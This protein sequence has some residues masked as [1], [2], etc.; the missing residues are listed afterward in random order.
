MLACSLCF[1]DGYIVCSRPDEIPAP[2]PSVRLHGIAVLPRGIK[3]RGR[4][5]MISPLS[6]E[7]ARGVRIALPPDPRHISTYVFLE[8]EDWFEDEADFVS[9]AAEPGGRMLDVGSSF[10][11]YSLNYARAGGAAARVWA[12][13]PTPEVCIL[14]RESIR[15][16]GLANMT[17]VET[18]VGAA[19]GRARFA[20]G[21]HSELNS[22]DTA[23]GSLE[24]A[25]ATLDDLDQ[26]HGFGTVDFVKLDVEGHEAEVVTGGV[27]F[28]KR[29][30]PL[31][32][33]EI[34]A[35]SVL[36]FTAAERF[37]ALGYA[38]YRLVPR[39]GVLVPFERTQVDPFLLN[40][41]ACKPDR[42]A[43]LADRGMLCTAI[44]ASAP[45]AERE[46]VAAC[47]RGI[48]AL[49]GHAAFFENLLAQAPADDP[50]TLLLRHEVASRNGS[51]PL[52]GRCAAL[53]AAA[54]IARQS[55]AAQ[56]GLAKMLGAA[57]VL[58]GW[59]E[60]GAAAGVLQRL[61]PAVLSGSGLSLD[62]PFLPPLPEYDARGGEIA[63]WLSACIVE[64]AALWS[65]YSSYWGEP[66]NVPTSDL[67]QRFGQQSAQFER[68][69]QLRRMLEGRQTGPQANP[70]LKAKSPENLNPEF[71][72]G[73]TT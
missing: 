53:A 19:S 47:I 9:R 22:L 5:T 41:F 16:N 33:L 34:K 64:A 28:F 29:E 26:E 45:R 3:Q 27:V 43:R 31:V 69:R 4:R 39:L 71:W 10:G 36:D 40:V 73:P 63:A 54:A 57:R 35:G 62:A 59:G 24:V 32:M 14:L 38:L 44:A 18:A 51:I 70:L 1:Q 6:L 30:S 68:R 15:Q 66:T 72:C 56:L 8:Q 52:P 7:I 37:E 25:V 67:L 20:A 11:F 12:F 65:T 55:A 21:L 58:R 13:E 48:P 46:E 49:A 23:R 50:A 42:A 2:I 17:L 61:L 60:R